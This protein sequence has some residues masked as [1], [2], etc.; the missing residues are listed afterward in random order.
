[1][2]GVVTLRAARCINYPGGTRG[3]QLTLRYAT[4]LLTGVTLFA[5]PQPQTPPQAG[6]PAAVIPQVDLQFVADV[7]RTAAAFN[8]MVKSMN[9]P[10]AF[11]PSAQVTDQ[12]GRPVNHQAAALGAGAGIGAAVGAMTGK[13]NGALIGAAVGGTSALVIEEI[14]KH[15]QPNYHPK[16]P[17]PAP[18]QP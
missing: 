3:A 15:P 18:Q 11:N 2:K 1:M 14:L 4:I 13:R 5:A 12:S 8:A 6:P 9:L 16:P 17:S 10:Q 7:M